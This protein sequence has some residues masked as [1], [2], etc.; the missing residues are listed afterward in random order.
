MAI[1]LHYDLKD[2]VRL[3]TWEGNAVRNK[4]FA[5]QAIPETTE[6]RAKCCQVFGRPPSSQARIGREHRTLPHG[7]AG[8]TQMRR[9]PRVGK[10]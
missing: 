6:N 2:V 4:A 8:T 3:A 1:E 5:I 10:I 7:P 9:A